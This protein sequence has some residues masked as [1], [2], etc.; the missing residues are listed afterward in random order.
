MVQDHGRG[1]ISYIPEEVAAARRQ[2]AEA[3]FEAMIAQD[4]KKNLVPP[5]IRKLHNDTLIETGKEVKGEPC[6]A[7]LCRHRVS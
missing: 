3:Q 6:K 1:A 5:K 7:N 2:E 4:G